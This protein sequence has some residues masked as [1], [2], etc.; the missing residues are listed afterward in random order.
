MTFSGKLLVVL[1]LTLSIFFM[2]FAGAINA[3]RIKFQDQVKAEAD[4]LS[5][6]RKKTAEA[7]TKAV[8][9]EKDLAAA[10][11]AAA[12]A[13]KK[14][15]EQ[16]ELLKSQI[17][18]LAGENRRGREKET[19]TMATL[20]SVSDE[21]TKR[22]DEIKSLRDTRDKLLKDNTTLVTQKANAED[23]IA[24]LKSQLTVMQ[25]RN[26]QVVES[27]AR[28][29]KL[30]AINNIKGDEVAEYGAVPPPPS[31]EGVVLS[32]DETGRYI[33]ISVG[34]DDGFQNGQVISVWRT[35]KDAKY[36]CDIKLTKVSPT[37]SIANPVGTS[38]PNP[39][40]ERDRVG[41]NILSSR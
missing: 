4:K 13:A 33:K 40:R 24:K 35:G 12:D 22:N 36:V 21:V 23:E 10:K 3:S 20:S 6:E 16:A 30:L 26:V 14:A 27:L 17:T 15:A 9:F 5:G 29:E 28:A 32:V 18:Q 38:T 1:N 34:S 31:V 19:A 41:A 2:V 8:Q 7:E 37:E 11:S 39:I 25:E